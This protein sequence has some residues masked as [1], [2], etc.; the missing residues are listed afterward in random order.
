MLY[1]LLQFLFLTIFFSGW[2][3]F[4]IGKNISYNWLNKNMIFFYI[5][6]L[7]LVNRFIHFALFDSSFIT[8]KY[9]ISDYLILL[10]IS[11]LSFRITRVNYLE[12]QYPWKYKKINIIKFIEI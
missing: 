4:Q 1:S 7:T 8:I 10:S 6:L 11:F 12:K 3:S 9:L 2:S 5:L